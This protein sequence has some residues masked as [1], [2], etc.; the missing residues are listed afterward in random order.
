MGENLQVSL[1]ERGSKALVLFW[2]GGA[3]WALLAFHVLMII[4]YVKGMIQSVSDVCQ[5]EGRQGRAGGGEGEVER[6]LRV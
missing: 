2:W 3:V 6:A 1:L 5:M 4:L